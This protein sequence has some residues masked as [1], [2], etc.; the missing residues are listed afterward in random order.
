MK[1]I[2]HIVP[3]SLKGIVLLFLMFGT[4]EFVTIAAQT[5]E[6][7]RQWEQYKAKAQEEYD[8]YSEKE[9]EEYAAFR[10]KANEEYALF[11]KTEWKSVAVASSIMPP[12]MPKP[13]A[14]I[15][16]P[17]EK[18]PSRRHIAVGGIDKIVLEPSLVPIPPVSC[19]RRVKKS[20]VVSYYGT[21]VIVHG[22]SLLRFHLTSIDGESLSLVW[23]QLSSNMYEDLLY[24]CLEVKR[25]RQFGDWAY[26]EF[27]GQVSQTLLGRECDEAVVLQ[28]WL[29]TQSGYAVRISKIE[30]Q[31]VIMVPFR[32][33]IFG[34][35]FI[36]RNGTR[37]YALTKKDYGERAKCTFCD[38]PFPREHV[39]SIGMINPPI[40]CV[41]QTQRKSLLKD[42]E[43]FTNENLI[44][45]YS[46]YPL[47]NEWG[48]YARVSFSHEMKKVLYPQLQEILKNVGEKEKVRILLAW[49]QHVF[50]Y[51]TD[52][53]Q[54]GYEKPMFADES[55]YY[56]FNDCEDRSIVFVSLV[57]DLVGLDVTLIEYSKH[58]A[59]AVAFPTET[60]GDYIEVDGRKYVVCDPTYIGADIGESMPDLKNEN[61]NVVLINKY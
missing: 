38:I 31:L 19:P 42:V 61:V 41:E 24:D 12:K 14:P 50:R 17:R 3:H 18:A 23:K 58:M 30:N 4:S 7:R 53:E 34:Y 25:T 29:L 48:L 35:G 33:L 1:T 28:T 21:P 46:N 11:L 36:D 60:D 39:A 10:K 5:D 40:L 45:F 59:T 9:K 47:S 49:V 32:E 20:M 44:D 56:P 8:A 57:R 51:K 27:C 2:A 55:F 15:Q 16:S 26:V 43:V 22:D 6:E 54:F 52:Q 13:P 37:Y